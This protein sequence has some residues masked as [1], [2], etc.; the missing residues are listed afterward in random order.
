MSAL[1]HGLTAALRAPVSF[2]LAALGTLAI[3]I[4]ASTVMFTVV[5]SF[6]L[7][8]LP[9]ENAER[10]TMVWQV[11]EQ[12]ERAA[13]EHRL[14]LSP[15]VFTDLSELAGSFDATAALVSESATVTGAG[16][17]QRVQLM[18]VSGP[19]FRL[20]G[21]RAILGR[22][23]SAEDERPDAP[24]V[25][26][27]THGY[28]RRLLA[29]EPGA[30]GRTLRIGSREH[31]IVG[32]LPAGFRF[33]ESL[34]AADPRFSKPP[35]VWVPFDLG[36]RAS[37]RGFHY[38]TVVARLAPGTDLEAARQEV[39]SYAA[40]AAVRYPETD[41]H[42]GLEIVSLHDQ[43]FGHLREVLLLLWAATG[44][45]LFIACANLATLLLARG[46][47]GHREVAVRLA[48]G[49]D[50]RRIV[51]ESLLAS[52]SLALL[53]GLAA[54]FVA[55]AVTELLTALNPL[56]VFQGYPPRIDLTVVLFTLGIS[57]VAG[58]L[59]GLLPAYRAS[60]IEVATGLQERAAVVT[61]GSRLVFSA[62]VVVE[63]AL[64]TT[65]LIGTGLAVRTYVHL[66][67]AE[68]GV[69]TERV[70]AMDI[71]LSHREYRETHRKTAFFRHL[72]ERTARLPGVEGV[73]MNYALPFSGVNPSNG[74][75]IVGRPA[76]EGDPMS[77]NLGLV[78]GGYFETM[79][80][81][82]LRGRTFRDTDREDAAKVAIVDRRMAERHFA[83]EDPLGREITIAGDTPLTVVGVVGAVRQDAFEKPARPYV[84]LPFQQRSYMYTSLAVRTAE[85]DPL[86]VADAVRDVVR[87]LDPALPL[88]NVSTLDAAYRKAIAP[89]RFSLLLI[90]A[91]SGIALILALVGIYGVMS[92]LARQRR[93]EIGIRMALGADPRKVF[94]LIARQGLALSLTGTL[95]GLALAL[96]VARLLASL[97][98][99]IA[100]DDVLVFASVPVLILL[101][102]FLAYSLPARRLSR[103]QPSNVLRSGA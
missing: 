49:A 101:A 39:A 4:G 24:P 56:N 21:T 89:Q 16:E 32:V 92:F 27:V 44:L 98:Y 54:V 35:D 80:I 7:S 81:P 88:Y 96:A 71:Y 99:G 61:R 13:A 10:L 103:R 86:A 22:T 85:E 102:A 87:D 42:Y 45:V 19:L 20:L 57:L 100:T 58:L 84:Y 75:G 47:T 1:R 36:Q 37:E 30:L 91:I 77:A 38:L 65:L 9:Y 90:G 60:R 15:G 78:D 94:R 55:Y 33:T 63:I 11:S 68:L 29:G 3:S 6:L 69:N 48:L 70:V 2:L 67:R 50:R 59:F 8:S 17:P 23:L 82:L 73:G 28:W 26:V 79:G 66:L 40:R 51:R 34:V 97:V 74:F 43:I 93:R 64:A 46:R 5:D 41:R 52:L 31:E 76:R 12:P 83:G 25:A 62:L 18:V 95:L 72:L 14:A 53:G